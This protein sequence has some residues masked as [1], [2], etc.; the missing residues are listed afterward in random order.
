MIRELACACEECSRDLGQ[1]EFMLALETPEGE[2]RAY[3]CACGAV[4]VTVVRE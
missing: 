2:R 4:T 1:S 3:E